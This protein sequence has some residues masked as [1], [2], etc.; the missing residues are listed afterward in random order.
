MLKAIWMVI[1]ILLKP[2]FFLS[3]GSCAKSDKL[4]QVISRLPSISLSTYTNTLHSVVECSSLR[5][6]HIN[7]SAS[8]HSSSLKNSWQKLKRQN[9]DTSSSNKCHF[10]LIKID[11][12]YFKILLSFERVPL[13][14]SLLLLQKVTTTYTQEVQGY[15]MH[16]MKGNCILYILYT[17]ISQR[18]S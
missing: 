16:K 1:L 9:N 5:M 10:I 13:R 12:F 6:L 11:F 3:R 18:S 2:F 14:K 8:Y 15:L 4:P 7:N 17:W